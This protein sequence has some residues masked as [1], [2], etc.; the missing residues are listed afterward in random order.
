MS[1]EYTTPKKQPLIIVS[2]SNA[3]LADNIIDSL[4]KLNV[5]SGK[6]LAEN[7][8][9]INQ[10][11][12]TEINIKLLKSVRHRDVFI[13][14]TG[15]S[16]NHLSINDNLIETTMLVSACYRSG[17]RNISVI[18]AYLP[19]SRSDKKDH[20]GT[21]GAKFVID[22]LTMVHANRIIC[23]DLHS[24]QI[25]GMTDIPMDN[26]YAVTDICKY[27][28]T[29]IFP[30]Y[31]KENCILVSPDAGGIKRTKAYAQILSMDY[32]TL[33]KQ[34]DY[35]VN[36][37]VLKSI[38]IGDAE[39]LKNKICIML[40]DMIDTAGT[41][42]AGAN[43]LTLYGIDGVIL[44]ATHGILS[45]PAKERIN[46]AT[47]VKE[48]IVTNTLPQKQHLV[49]CDKLKVVNV[50]QT[51]ARVIQILFEEAGESISELFDEQYI[52]KHLYTVE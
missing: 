12:N 14:A 10:F 20:R 41:M 11:A 2:R 17:A 16:D 37:S 34:R 26:I 43:E 49:N 35:K 31:G 18:L 22:M 45:D 42:I 24:G 36:N 25:Q 9:E 32:V 29:V 21:I 27:L 19:Y 5:L 46:C 1:S 4:I 39:L 30:K 23:M 7:I 40:D 48:V 28:S 6:E 44:V 51:F 50:G 13:I 15:G 47:C 3:E 52:R 38:L 8:C 33:E